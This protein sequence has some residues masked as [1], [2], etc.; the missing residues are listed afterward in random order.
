MNNFNWLLGFQ[1]KY[2]QIIFTYGWFIC[3]VRSGYF[4][5]SFF[6]MKK[7]SLE[8]RR[9]GEENVLSA[10]TRVRLEPSSSK[11][12][13]IEERKERGCKKRFFRMTLANA[14]FT[15]FGF[16]GEQNSDLQFRFIL[17]KDLSKRFLMSG[18]DES[19]SILF[20]AN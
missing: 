12:V 7:V 18:L 17:R 2:F 1:S 20:E 19:F 13:C 11:F 10:L 4:F 14:I 15:R 3:Y 6:P 8:L 5:R 9:M 16:R